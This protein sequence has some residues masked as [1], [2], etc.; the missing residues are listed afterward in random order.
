[1]IDLSNAQTDMALL[2][3]IITIL[4]AMVSWIRW[5]RPKLRKMSREV[6]A[7]RDSI[8][9]RDEIR[10]TITNELIAPELPGIGVRVANT[11]ELLIEVTGAISRLADTSDRLDDHERR[12]SR[13]EGAQEQKPSATTV[14]VHTA[15]EITTDPS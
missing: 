14:H 9:G 12:I 6:T 8:L 3:G 4:G 13:L 5:A 2:I 1:M 10:D 11:E 7:I 15:P